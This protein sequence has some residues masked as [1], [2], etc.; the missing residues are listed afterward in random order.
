MNDKLRPALIGG[1]VLGLLSAIPFVNILNVCCCAW[2]IIGG[3][4]ASYLYIGNSPIPAKPGD[5]AML[6][7]FSGLI[8]SVIYLIVGIP[9]S[10]LV[11]NTFNTLLIA[12]MEKIDPQQGEIFR[13]QMELA[14][15]L[16]LAQRLGQ[17][18]ISALIGV[19]L[20]TVFSTVGGLIGT[21]LFEKRK[22]FPAVPP[23]P[24]PPV[25]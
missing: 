1:V 20:L 14:Q 23:P 4:L 5:G 9:L 3:A 10:L 24:P 17:I 16:P 8:G 11:S 15:S 25:Y 6:G 22:E 18:I 12:M 21:A 19:A 13:R 2:A 7:A